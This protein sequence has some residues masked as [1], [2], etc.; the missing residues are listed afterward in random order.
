[1]QH[2][3]YP[4]IA[5]A[6]ST[7]DDGFL[8]VYPCDIPES[9]NYYF[10]SN[11]VICDRTRWL[12]RSAQVA[13]IGVANP[14]W[15]HALA[16]T[17]SLRDAS[18]ERLVAFDSNP[19]QLRHFVRLR[20]LIL[21][22][23]DRIRYLERLFCVHFGKGARHALEHLRDRRPRRVHG[24]MRRDPYIELERSLWRGCEFD[25]KAF[26][27]ETGL[28]AKP[29]T[30][31]L[32]IHS[33]TVGDIDEYMATFLCAS[34]ADYTWWPFT[35]A[36]GS[37]FLADEHR[38][39]NLRELLA[40]TPTYPILIDAADE[41]DDL[42]LAHRYQPVWL[43]TS[44]L[45]CDYFVEKHP[46]LEGIRNKIA[47]HGRATMPDAELDIWLHQDRREANWFDWRVNDWGIHHRPW[48]IHSESFHRVAKQLRGASGLEVVAESRWI[49][50][51]EG[52]SKLPNTRY[53][54]LE[55]FASAHYDAPH[56][57]IFLHILLGHGVAPD[58][59]HAV[60]EKARRLSPNV[61]ILEHNA[62]SKDFAQRTGGTT[63]GVLTKRHG[64]PSEV[65]F[66][67]GER[68]PDRNW[69]AVYRSG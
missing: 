5:L 49:D 11:D 26:E 20:Q 14:H 51:D 62:E 29:L 7:Q 37:G 22:S 19:E 16:L 68:C 3:A 67:P 48:S 46:P 47:R 44:N 39:Q 50:E 25:A 63:L 57:T 10:L 54:P 9:G 23:E 1:M 55:A 32:R 66:A 6:Q 2:L 28:V 60:V 64:L 42:L 24:A 35:A 15:F 43:W 27:S 17:T 56:S 52:I 21:E 65:D 58:D 41:L 30:A 18:L 34:R 8:S 4:G 12:T 53:C 31:G 33:E 38:F 40:N 59:F 61:V 36:F 45:L 69:I 13:F